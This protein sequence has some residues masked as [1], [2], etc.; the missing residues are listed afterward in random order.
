MS[1]VQYLDSLEAHPGAR[2]ASKLA[3]SDYSDA[4]ELADRE[5]VAFSTMVITRSLW[6]R[7]HRAVHE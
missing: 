3:V 5:V 4:S 6:R 1:P 2:M 7:D